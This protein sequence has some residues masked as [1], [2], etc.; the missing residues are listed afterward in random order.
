M[1]FLGIVLGCIIG[2]TF[3]CI[4][5]RY[6]IAGT[7]KTKRDTYDGDVYLYAELNE[8]ASGLLAYRN[9]VV[10]QVDRSQQ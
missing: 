9:Y 10:L 6:L 2:F 7:L 8:R 4:G 3:A 1:F 5:I